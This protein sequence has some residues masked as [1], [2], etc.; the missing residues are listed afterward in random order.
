MDITFQSDIGRLFSL[1]VLVS[2]VIFLLVILPFTFIEFFYAPWMK[3]QE[4]NKAPTKVPS[5]AERHVIFTHYGPVAQ[6]P[7]SGRAL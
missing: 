1:L 6:M 4:K 7:L 5:S 2:G 3:A